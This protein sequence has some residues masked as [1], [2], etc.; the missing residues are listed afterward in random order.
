MFHGINSVYMNSL[1]Q[2]SLSWAVARLLQAPTAAIPWFATFEGSPGFQFPDV[3]WALK[4]PCFSLPWRP[5]LTGQQHSLGWRCWPPPPP[6]L[7]AFSWT[8]LLNWSWFCFHSPW[9]LTQ[10]QCLSW[11]VPESIHWQ[12]DGLPQENDLPHLMY[13]TYGISSHTVDLGVTQI[14]MR[15]ASQKYW[16]KRD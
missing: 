2:M 13:F 12:Q 15:V 9:T 6:L 1:S 7:W 10:S 3:A 16:D 14:S 8:M 5:D 4:L 11:K